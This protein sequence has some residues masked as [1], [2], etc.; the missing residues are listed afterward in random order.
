LTAASAERLKNIPGITGVTRQIAT[1]IDQ[2]NNGRAYFLI[3]TSGIV[4]I[5]DQSMF[6][7]RK[8]VALTVETLPFYKMIITDYETAEN[9]VKNELQVNGTEIRINGKVVE[10]TFKQN[11]YWMMG[12]NRHN[13][14]DSRYWDLFLK[15]TL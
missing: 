11:Y 15:I 12:D 1:D 13:S 8:T 10:Y 3:P 7:K 5:T 6:Q 9:G 2:A 4:I 14:E